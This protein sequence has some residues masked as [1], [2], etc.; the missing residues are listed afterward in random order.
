MAGPPTIR[1]PTLEPGSHTLPKIKT[2]H[3]YQK[4]PWSPQQTYIFAGAL[5]IS[6]FGTV[7]A[8]QFTVLAGQGSPQVTQGIGAKANVIDRARR[9]GYTVPYGYD[10]IGLDIPIQFERVVANWDVGSGPF[11]PAVARPTLE[12]DI[13]V[14]YWMGGRG[15]LYAEK[16]E[17]GVG[18][19]AQGDP[20]IVRVA[21]F[22]GGGKAQS[23]LIPPDLHGVDWIIAAVV[24]D[25]SDTGSI[26]NAHGD[27]VRQAAS[28]SLLEYSP[29]PGAVFASPTVRAKNRNPATAGSKV[30]RTT[31]AI[32]TI[33]LVLQHYAHNT[34]TA[35]RKLTL[36]ANAKLKVTSWSKHLPPNTPVTVPNSVVNK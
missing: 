12:D 13:Q 10:P 6:E 14:L 2:A 28:V 8:R 21:S 16:A 19:A 27:L 34:T 3:P 22:F 15:K 11:V 32:D 17:G 33:A 18:A 26:R 4:A 7:K 36:N 9:L 29:A 25:N 1:P 30:Y 24:W 5:K 23:N 31:A 35:A 20:P